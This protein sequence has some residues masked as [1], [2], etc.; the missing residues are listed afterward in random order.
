MLLGNNHLGNVFAEVITIKTLFASAKPSAIANCRGESRG[1][2]VVFY[3]GFFFTF[4][5]F[6]YYS[7]MLKDLF[8]LIKAL[9]I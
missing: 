5:S 4:Y 6:S 7:S 3:K 8:N 1:L 9:P 2:S